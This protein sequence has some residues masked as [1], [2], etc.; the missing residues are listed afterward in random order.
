MT[1][2]C[3][4]EKNLHT[5]NHSKLLAELPAARREAR[6]LPEPGAGVTSE[7]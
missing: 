4:R 2:A 5:Q 6:D 7:V 3:P 1:R